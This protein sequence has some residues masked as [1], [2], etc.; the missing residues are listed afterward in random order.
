MFACVVKCQS[1]FMQGFVTTTE[2][3]LI[4]APRQA[5]ED[6]RPFPWRAKSAPLKSV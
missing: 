4:V 1:T 6:P 2:T 5:I 3:A